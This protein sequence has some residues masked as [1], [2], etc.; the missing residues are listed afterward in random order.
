MAETDLGDLQSE[1][2]VSSVAARIHARR[3]EL[4]QERVVALVWSEL[5]AMS[6]AP[7]RN[8]AEILVERRV[9]QNLRRTA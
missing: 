3:P 4:D 7:V 6:D 5:A 2:S 1:T 9:V 8:F